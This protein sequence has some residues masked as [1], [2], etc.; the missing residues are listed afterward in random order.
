MLNN[1]N[2]YDDSFQIGGNARKTDFS[3]REFLIKY[4]FLIP[5][6][7]VSVS[8]AL[9][10]TYTRL[11]YIVP[12]YSAS[13][14]VLIKQ[15]R[16]SG[17]N[18]GSGGSNQLI[19]D[20]VATSVNSRSMDDQIEL[21]KSTAMA[22]MVVRNASIQQSYY[23]KGK[24]RNTLTHLSISPIQLNILNL[25]DSANGISVLVKI[26]DK[27]TFSVNGNNAPLR[28]GSLF[29]L[30]QGSFVLE[31]KTAVIAPST[32]F[33]CTWTPE[34][35][36]A[37]SLAASINVG[38]ATKGGNVLNFAYFSENHLVAQDVVNG[39]LKAY[40]DYS[41]QDKR[42]GS[43][44]ALSFIDNQLAEVKGDLSNVEGSLQQFREDNKVIA[45][46]AQATS[47]FAEAKGS[48][49]QIMEQSVKIRF[50]DYMINFIKDPKNNYRSIPL[51]SMVNEASVGS[52][53]AEYNKLQLQ[54]E[55]SLQTIP[56]DNP[57]IRDMELSMGKVRN[58]IVMTLT[59]FKETMNEALK[60]F[61][62]MELEAN[63]ELRSLPRKQRQLLDISR[64]QQVIQELYSSLVQRKIQISIS[65][66]STLSNIQVLEPGYSG[67]WPVSPNP[68]SLY[69]T[70]ILIGLAIPIGLAVLR[71]LLND[72]VNSKEDIRKFTT[73]P[74]L[75]E[76][77][78]SDETEYLIVRDT[79]RNMIAEQFRVI[80]AN[81]QYVLPRQSKY[82]ILVT[83]S[84]SGEGKSFVATNM[85]GVMAVS[86]KKTVILEFDIRKPKILEGLGIDRKNVKGVTNYLM[87]KTTI[88]DI[89]IPV[90]KMEN[91]FVIACGPVPPN[92]AELILD[93]KLN[94]L[95]REV[96]ERFDVV[97]I[98]T[99]PVGLVSDAIEL[100]LHA[101]AS[102]FIV[103]HD[104]TYKKQVQLV[105]ELYK[106]GKLPNLSIII[107][108][109]QAMMGYGKYYGYVSY[110]YIGYGYGSER[111]ISNYFD[112]AV[113]KRSLWKRIRRAIGV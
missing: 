1:N 99:A 73:A 68:R 4:I 26:I 47:S 28:F 21:I 41:L 23:Y 77:G 85:A 29:Q 87:G 42:E 61:Q 43:M 67:G 33:I 80:R 101:D 72:K 10:I 20:V 111:Y 13:G 3:T 32:E 16:P 66:A 91:L 7:I 97:L 75:G 19:G 64:Q 18:S 58:E 40:Q 2:N 78:H 60:G 31:K 57:I 46:E 89:I 6:L 5:W 81:F 49:K 86:G 65:S 45:P 44:S 76:I 12:I 25:T 106:G 27:E 52:I 107:N 54:R 14:K 105:E 83:S 11:R 53:I 93:P 88:D 56:K 102:V 109:V 110:G 17:L 59:Q 113:K 70:A 96:K 36:L 92:P 94:D 69:I 37:R 71:E 108:D 74:M 90:A 55:I 34:E 95:F 79:S 24:L 104:F 15:D 100:G 50:I 22:R 84:M 39:F 62:E 35:Q 38:L 9:G 98:D 112:V 48:D 8:I 51:V 30:A 63:S 82:T 103:R